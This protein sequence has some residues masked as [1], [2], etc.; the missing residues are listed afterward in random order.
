MP[1]GRF[2]VEWRADWEVLLTGEAE[3]VYEGEWKSK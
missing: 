3:I 2:E 1:G